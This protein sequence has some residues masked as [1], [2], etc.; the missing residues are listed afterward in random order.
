MTESEL[1]SAILLA[2]PMSDC[3]IHRNNIGVTRTGKRTIRYGL[4]IGS[5]DLIGILRDGRFLAIEVKTAIGRQTAAQVAFASMV[6]SFGGV[7][8]L[9]RSVSDA[10]DGIHHAL[11]NSPIFKGQTSSSMRYDGPGVHSKADP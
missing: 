2:V 5:A 1:Q 7:F 11:C 4:W 8:I 9:A 3:R 6:V 10:L